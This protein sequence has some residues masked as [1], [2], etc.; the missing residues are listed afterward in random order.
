MAVTLTS[1]RS[2][3]SFMSRTLL[4]AAESFVDDFFSSRWRFEI[5]VFDLVNVGRS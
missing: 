1:L 2:V 4:G 3:R 5:S